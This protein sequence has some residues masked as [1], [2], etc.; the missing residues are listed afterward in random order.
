MHN[1]Q[2]K[3][4]KKYDMVVRTP[5]GTEI[6]QVDFKVYPE[7]LSK[8]RS[9]LMEQQVGHFILWDEKAVFAQ[10]QLTQL[11][12]LGHKERNVSHR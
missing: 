10:E 12:R 4:E 7:N 9:A 3:Q 8:E 1:S 6:A 2:N 5:S 11:T